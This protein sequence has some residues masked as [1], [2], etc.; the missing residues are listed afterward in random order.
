VA[1]FQDL[2]RLLLAK[3]KLLER[4]RAASQS[5]SSSWQNNKR[6]LTL[7]PAESTSP[8]APTTRSLPSTARGQQPPSSSS[9]LQSA[10]SGANARPAPLPRDSRLGQYVEF[11]LSKLHN[12]KGGFLV[13]EEDDDERSLRQR[14][15]VEELR[16]QRIR[17][18]ER[19]GLG[20][21]PRWSFLKKFCSQPAHVKLNVMICPIQQYHSTR[22]PILSARSATRPSS[23][24]RSTRSLACP[25]AQS[26][27]RSIRIGS[28][29]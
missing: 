3:A 19:M 16:K 12:S 22:R 27:E 7:T 10:T 6:P 15:Q 26:A 8:T 21:E 20:Q 25:S 11:D 2:N 29:S 5:N 23:T 1:A 18:S 17:E 4:E 28:V 9:A 24:F 14:R 13:E